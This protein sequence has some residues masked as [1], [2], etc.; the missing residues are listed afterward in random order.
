MINIKNPS[1]LLPEIDI[2]DRIVN[3]V[4]TLHNLETSMQAFLNN[5][6]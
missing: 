4:K 3:Y 6:T 5:T 1:L 2:S